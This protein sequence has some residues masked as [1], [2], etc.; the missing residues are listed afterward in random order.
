MTTPPHAGR[1][2]P[3]W[4]DTAEFAAYPRLE[5]SADREV[6]VVG[7]GIAGLSAAYRLARRENP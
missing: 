2:S 3:L 6:C 1:T 5:E 7:A 4:A